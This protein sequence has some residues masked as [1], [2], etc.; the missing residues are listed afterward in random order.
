MS[1]KINLSP[2]LVFYGYRIVPDPETGKIIPIIRK[3]GLI[4]EKA[5]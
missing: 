3:D 4:D 1:W 5:L 2:T